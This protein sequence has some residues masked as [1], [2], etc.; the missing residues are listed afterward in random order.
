MRARWGLFVCSFVCLF[1]RSFGVFV[2]VPCATA[3]PAP[4]RRQHARKVR[5]G[6]SGYS[7]MGLG[8]PVPAGYGRTR[9][10]SRHAQCTR[11]H[12]HVH[13][14]TS[15]THA[16]MAGAHARSP[17]APT[18]MHTHSTGTH[19]CTGVLTRT[20]TRTRIRT[21]ARARAHTHPCTHTHMRVQAHAPGVRVERPADVSGAFLIRNDP[22]VEK[23]GQCRTRPGVPVYVT[24]SPFDRARFGAGLAAW[25]EPCD[26]APV[27]R[28]QTRATTR[29]KAE[30]PR[31]KLRV[32]V[33]LCVG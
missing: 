3:G 1:V 26:P 30:P 6:Y 25:A 19:A 5:W 20:H 32:C 33:C 29:W 23:T 18:H 7:H 16:G 10:H 24:F 11:A 15:R 14:H 28:T 17:P 27:E 31:S 21:H 4:V 12:P 22:L 9:T 8:G 2:V 13:T